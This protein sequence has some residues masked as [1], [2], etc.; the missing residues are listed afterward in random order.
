MSSQ[1]AIAYNIQAIHDCIVRDTDIFRKFNSKSEKLALYRKKNKL[2]DK[3]PEIKKM[4]DAK[5]VSSLEP[6]RGKLV[7]KV[8][9]LP[10]ELI[11]TDQRI[12]EMCRNLFTYSKPVAEKTGIAFGPCPGVEKMSGCPMFSPGP[13]E[14]RA[15][16]DQA[17]IFIAMQSIYFMEPPGI[18]GWHDFLIRKLKKEIEK[19][20]G[21]GSVTA[22]FGAGPCQMCHPNPCLGG[23]KC[24]APEEHLFS[25]ESVG[26]PVSQLCRDMALLT[27]NKD[28][29]V[30]FIKY[31]STSRQSHKEWKLT[32]GLAVKLQQKKE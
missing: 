3:H 2:L 14:M 8:G 7:G 13:E 16:L 5:F 9:W 24:R 27:G 32:S 26:I 1:P 25:L 11:I 23:G 31:Y 29:K 21:V 22:A 28:W 6:K 30:R 4:V 12:R 18:P 15:K 17:D 10:P 19:I 20:A